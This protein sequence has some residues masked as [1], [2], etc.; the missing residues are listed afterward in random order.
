MS[1][2]KDKLELKVEEAEFKAQNMLSSF[3]AWQKWLILL[4][5]IGSLPGYFLAKAVGNAY[6]SRQYGKYLIEAH[7]SFRDAKN[8]ILDRIDIASLGQNEYAAVAQVINPNLDLAA[9][10]LTYKFKFYS[11]DGA[12]IAASQNGQFFVLPNQ[13]KYLIMPKIISEKGIERVVLILPSE[14]RWQRKLD[15]P[16]IKLTTTRPKGYDQS[17]PFGYALEGSVTNNS[18]YNLKEIRL[19]FLLYGSGG[20]TIGASSRSEFNIKPFEKRDYKQIWPAVSG[21]NVVRTEAFAE[22]NLLDKENLSAPVFPTDNGAGN[23]SR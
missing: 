20:K 7:P 2:F 9:K 8:L 21:R 1:L 18:A 14:I 17:S 22:T 4:C 15:L 11:A 12:E 23:L 10:N 6:F 5:I 16:E 13:R 19:V 3:A